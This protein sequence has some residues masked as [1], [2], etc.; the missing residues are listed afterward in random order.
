MS[1]Y[2]ILKINA[3]ILL[4]V[5][6]GYVISQNIP[7]FHQSN[8]KVASIPSHF[9]LGADFSSQ[10]YFD[11]EL[12]S[13]EVSNDPNQASRVE[14]KITALKDFPNGIS[15]EWN[16]HKN[17]TINDESAGTISALKAG[18]VFTREIQITGFHKNEQSHVSLTIK[19]SFGKIHVDRSA[20]LASQ[21]D[22]TLEHIVQEAAKNQQQ[23]RKN[24]GDVDAQS[25]MTA[26]PLDRFKPENVV[27]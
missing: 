12:N 20:I 22:Q 18:E 7:Q 3:V 6:C 10:N 9:K 8:R 11:L 24:E 1:R 15:Y 2:D 5:F 27:K 4:G 21:M 25:K 13:L 19:G 26:S 16:K 23:R 17:H 14:M